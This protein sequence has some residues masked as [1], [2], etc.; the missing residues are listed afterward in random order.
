[1]M[2]Q[3]SGYPTLRVPRDFTSVPG[4]IARIAYFGAE[5]V[6]HAAQ[7]FP[8]TAADVAPAWPGVE[9]KY[10]TVVQA[11]GSQYDSAA[12]RRSP[13]QLNSIRLARVHAHLLFQA[14]ATT[15]HDDGLPALPESQCFFTLA[16]Q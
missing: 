2:Q 16:E 15:D 12:A 5:R 1:M 10:Q 9:R 11:A 8:H 6:G 4:Q 3:H 14:C 13:Q 7:D